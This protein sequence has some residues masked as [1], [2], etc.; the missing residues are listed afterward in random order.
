MGL[1]HWMGILVIITPTR[2][3]GAWII[4]YLYVLCTVASLVS[5]VTIVQRPDWTEQSWSSQPL[6][7]LLRP[8]PWAG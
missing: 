7:V 8:K 4:E 5:I 2:A 6:S 3:T 1:V